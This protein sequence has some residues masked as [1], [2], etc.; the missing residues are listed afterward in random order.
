M[1][2]CSA[3]DKVGVVAMHVVST[4]TTEKMAPSSFLIS[5]LILNVGGVWKKGS[6]SAEAS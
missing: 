4:T 2:R 5:R 3:V 6:H 1:A